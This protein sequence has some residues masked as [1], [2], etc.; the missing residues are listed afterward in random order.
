MLLQWFVAHLEHRCKKKKAKSLSLNKEHTTTPQA[1]YKHK[2]CMVWFT[3]KYNFANWMFQVIWNSLYIYSFF[4]DLQ[5]IDKH[6]YFDSFT[7][8]IIIEYANKF[9]LSF[10]AN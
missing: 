4:M 3:S 7:I 1:L 10:N 2:S 9:L 8:I 6:K 5:K